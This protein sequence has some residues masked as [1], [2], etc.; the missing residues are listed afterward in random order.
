MFLGCLCNRFDRL[1]QIE[2]CFP[3][4]DLSCVLLDL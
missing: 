2:K 3:I 4:F 1:E